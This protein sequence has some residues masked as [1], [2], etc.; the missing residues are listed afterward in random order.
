MLNPSSSSYQLMLSA[1]QKQD[2][3]VETG[4]HLSIEE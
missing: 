3:I 1:H 2:E 4:Q